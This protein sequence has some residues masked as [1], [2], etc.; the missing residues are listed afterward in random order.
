MFNS[1]TVGFATIKKGDASVDVAFDMDYDESPIVNVSLMLDPFTPTPQ[2]DN[3]KASEG[4]NTKITIEERIFAEN[5]D[6]LITKR[7]TNGFTIL[8]R[9]PAVE[10]ISFSWIALEAGKSLRGGE[11]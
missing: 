10:D 3:P 11:D 2:P 4:A 5:I 7:T 6:Y 9:R 8:L 1:D